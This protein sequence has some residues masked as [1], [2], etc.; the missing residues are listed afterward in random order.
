MSAKEL[1]ERKNTLLS[2]KDSNSNED[3][4]KGSNFLKDMKQDLY[5]DSGLKLEDRLNRNAHHRGRDIR[6][7]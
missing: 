1:D 5:M 7:E 3:D 6:R 4:K 2:R